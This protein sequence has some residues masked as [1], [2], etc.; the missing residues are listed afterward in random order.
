MTTEEFNK[1]LTTLKRK[2]A[3]HSK[4]MNVFNNLARSRNM[5]DSEDEEGYELLENIVHQY[6]I[7]MIEDKV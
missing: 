4:L 3:Q 1:I 2:C 5:W 6:L 7:D